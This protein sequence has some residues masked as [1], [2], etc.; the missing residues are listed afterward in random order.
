MVELVLISISPRMSFV[1]V[2]ENLATE[3]MTDSLVGSFIREKLLDGT[4]IKITS[5]ITHNKPDILNNPWSG[6]YWFGLGRFLEY[7][8]ICI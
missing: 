6:R 8:I 3:N 5:T 4:I 1:K 7:K 2:G